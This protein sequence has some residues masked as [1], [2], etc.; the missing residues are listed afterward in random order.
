MR[1]LDALRA[2]VKWVMLE[3]V[4]WRIDLLRRRGPSAKQLNCSVSAQA[5][6]ASAPHTPLFGSCRSDCTGS[7]PHFQRARGVVAH[8]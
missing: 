4:W 2:E 3:G 5:W 8:N 7:K 6:N 1:K